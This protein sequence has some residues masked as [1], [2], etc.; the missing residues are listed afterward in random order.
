MLLLMQ[1]I[2]PVDTIAKYGP[3]VGSAIICTG[4][5]IWSQVQQWQFRKTL[6]DHTEKVTTQTAAQLAAQV[7]A[8]TELKGIVEKMVIAQSDQAKSIHQLAEAIHH[9]TDRQGEMHQE[10][11]TLIREMVTEQK[12]L[13]QS[14]T[15]I[16]NGF[17]RVVESLI[18][19]M[20]E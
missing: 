4:L 15:T 18:D 16:T 7:A 12:L 5:F 17:Q 2:N 3:G 14:Q 6:E 9:Q 10:Q 13:A 11:L 8:N 19:A 1:S 20:K